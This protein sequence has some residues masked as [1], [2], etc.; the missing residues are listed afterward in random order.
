MYSRIRETSVP[1]CWEL[2][3]PVHVDPRGEFV[4][5]SQRDALFELGLEA[6]FEETYYTVSRENVLR[7]MHLQLPPAD[8]GKLVYCVAGA[9]LDVVLDVRTGSP[10]YGRFAQIELDGAGHNGLYIPRGVAHGF[11]VLRAPAAMAYHVTAMHAPQLDA[12][13]AWD[14]FGACWPAASPL[15]S[16]RDAGLPPL[17]EFRSPFRYQEA[18]TPAGEAR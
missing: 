6:D 5:T 3:F 1:G 4:K 12:G 15:I 18:L 16:P 10:A 17:A 9:V 8:H 14:S 2:H 11:Y 7:G 13:I